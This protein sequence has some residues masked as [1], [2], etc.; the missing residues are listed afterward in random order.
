MFLLLVC[1]K[2]KHL[3]N[4]Q[5]NQALPFRKDYENTKTAIK[6]AEENR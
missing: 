6:I 4:E 2:K 5:S 1:L 3:Q